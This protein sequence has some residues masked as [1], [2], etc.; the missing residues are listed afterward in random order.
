MTAMTT[1]PT[2]SKVLLL[3]DDRTVGTSAQ[4]LQ[5][6]RFRIARVRPENRPSMQDS[7]ISR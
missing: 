3:T 4:N 2:S 5:I 1:H 7:R 6:R